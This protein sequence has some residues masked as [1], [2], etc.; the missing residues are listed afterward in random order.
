VIGAGMG[1]AAGG[2]IVFVVYGLLGL[3]AFLPLVGRLALLQPLASFPR[4]VPPALA[5]IPMAILLGAIAGGVTAL[6]DS[7]RLGAVVFGALAVL[8]RALSLP[9]ADLSRTYGAFIAVYGGALILVDGVFGGACGYLVSL[10]VSGYLAA[11]R[12]RPSD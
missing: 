9:G 11:T 6:R 2:L 1:G 10:V 12:Q 3:I 4:G 7:P 8:L 5:A